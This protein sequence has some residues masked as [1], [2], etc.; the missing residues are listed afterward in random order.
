MLPAADVK[1]LA[2]WVYNVLWLGLVQVAQK[3]RFLRWL[4]MAIVQVFVHDCVAGLVALY[5]RAY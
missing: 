1:N 5:G 3:G 2:A 4:V